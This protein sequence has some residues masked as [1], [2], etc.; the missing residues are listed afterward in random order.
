MRSINLNDFIKVGY[1]IKSHG[2][3]GLLKISLEKNSNLKEWVMFLI[4]QK[5]VPFFVEEWQRTTE[6][7]AIIKCLD[8]N[9]VEKAEDYI[10][11]D[12]LI[13][14]A[15][16][17]RKKGALDTSFIGFTM[18]DNE[19]GEIG[20]L[21]QIIEMPGQTM[22]QTV[23]NRQEILI[24]AVEEFILEINVKQKLITLNLP[25]GFLELNV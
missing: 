3:N 17:K 14:S 7:E 21:L 19:I 9:T 23:Y 10:G 20:N 2:N 4:K 22:F 11:L 8:I 6:N 15:S 1:V 18:F 25:D 12:I 24:P 16:I 5:P 13:P